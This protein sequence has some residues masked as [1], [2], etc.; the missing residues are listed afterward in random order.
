MKNNIIS[1]TQI[2][3]GGGFVK[4]YAFGTLSTTFANLVSDNNV[5]YSGGVQDGGF[6]SGSLSNNAGTSY[7]TLADWTAATSRDSNSIEVAPVFVAPT[8][9]HL[10]AGSNSIIEATPGLPIASVTTDMDCNPRSATTPAIGA[11]EI[12]VSG[13]SISAAAGTGGTITPAGTTLVAVGGNQSYTITANC[14]YAVADVLV[15]GVSQGAITTYTFNNV[16]ASHLITARFNSQAPTI[17]ASG[18]TTYCEGGSVTLTSSSATGNLWS[19]GETTQSI[20]AQASGNYFV[21][22]T[23]G[24]CYSPISESVTVTI[25]APQAAPTIAVSGSGSSFCAGGSATLTSSAL[26][27]NVWSTGETTR[28][29][30]VT[31]SGTYTVSYNNG[32]CTSAVSAGTT[33]T[34]IPRI[35][36]T[37]TA[38]GPTTFCQGDSVVLTSSSA[39]GNTWSTGAT[40]Q[41]ITIGVSGTYTVTVSGGCSS[42]PSNAITTTMIA[43]PARPTVIVTGTT[44]FCQGGSAVLTSSATEGNLWSNG[45]TTQAITVTTSGVYTVTS[46]VDGCTSNAS[47]ARTI[48]VNPA[49]AT[50]TITASG[51]TTFCTGGSVTLTSS[52]ATGNTWSTG[53]TT[54]SIT[55]SASGTYTVKVTSGSCTSLISD[56]TTV[57]VNSIPATPTITASGTT[58]FCTGGSVTLTSSSATGNVWSNGETTASITVT[59]TGNYSVTVAENGCSS[60]AASSAISVTVNPIPATPTITASGATTF[61]QGGSVTLT[62][63]SAT[64]NL[65]SNG[66]TNQSITVSSAGDYSVTV[67]TNGCSSSA[68]SDTAVT[69]NP[70]PATPTITASGATTFCQGGSVTLTSSSATGN[71]WSNGATTQSITVSSAGDYSVAVTANGCSSSTSADTSVTVNSIPATP[72]ITASGATTF[73]TGGSV[74]LTSSSATGNVWSNG[75]TTASITVSSA[76]DYSVAVTA[77]GCSS[78]T[79]ADTSVTVNAIPATPTITASGATTFCQG[80]SV[81]LTS[82]SAT[83]NVWSNGATT[84]SITVSSAGDYSVAVTANGCSSSTSADTSVTVNAIPAT[85]TIT[86]SGATTFCTGGSVTLTSSSATGNVW[87]N[88]ETTA[89]ITVSSAGDYSVAVTANGCSSST[90]SDTSVTVNAIPATP[91]ITA[92]GATTFCTGE[93]VTLTSSSATGNVWSNGAT[94]QSITVSSAGDYS[95]AVTANGCSSS[96]S[97][98]TS[99]T[100]NP[101]PNGEITQSA[102]VI[103]A[104]QSGATYQWYS[105][106]N[107]LIDGA[108][109]QTYTPMIVGDYRVEITLGS[110][111][112]SSDCITVTELGAK[113]FDLKEFKLYPNPVTDILNVEYTNE[114][115]DVSV[116]NMLGQ[117]I[118]S[119][120]GGATTT[121]VDMSRLPSASYLVKVTSE[122]ASKTFK[123]IKK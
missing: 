20:V 74:T 121:T 88:G 6:R 86:A 99:V 4:T 55:V 103:T 41:S 94:T 90:S 83:G 113:D 102:G 116:F 123:V 51:A 33:I 32:V 64:G 107:T 97:A 10:V 54:Q 105:C 73:C 60:S 79:S 63:S 22:A 23:N 26:T 111:T 17:T 98:D 117:K 114:I 12:N 38:S 3:T 96:I 112:Q 84:Q 53:A 119:N 57:T 85:P 95:V 19:T 25:M 13:Y 28:S 46:T 34:V 1:T 115:T 66:A 75:E 120:N 71:V 109:D 104:A 16:T 14:G 70:I 40:T 93:S 91:T 58:T 69:V 29:I 77:N 118:I 24:N 92:S 65:W 9:L 42:L 27:G 82:S 15:D 31:T 106:P 8:N 100:V 44:T 89:S 35:V 81:T 11:H 80:G 78:S 59:S 48:T 5:F 18:P 30:T 61:C 68:S 72:T 108:T 21:S 7:A 50:P 52:S 67:I 36:A 56:A 76:G 110:C 122:N 43:K 37:I 87:S 49:P 39:S 62:S 101:A 2:A 47:T 45:E